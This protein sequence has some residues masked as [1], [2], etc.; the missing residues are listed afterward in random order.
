MGNFLRATIGGLILAMLIAQSF[1]AGI[2]VA[3]GK[4][5]DYVP[6]FILL[7]FFV[8]WAVY[9]VIFLVQDVISDMRHEQL[10]EHL[11]AVSRHAEHELEK[12]L[13]GTPKTGESTAQAG[14][15]KSTK[16]ASTRKK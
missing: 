6:D 11:E 4:P 2:A 1:F 9:Y 5:Q 7:I 16:R 10:M 13:R 14:E 3:V 8:L 15:N 12:L